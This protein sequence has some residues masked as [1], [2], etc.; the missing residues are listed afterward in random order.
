[1]PV[2]LCDLDD[3]LF[4]HDRATREALAVLQNRHQVLTRWSLDELDA[5]HRVWLETMHLEV[6]AGRL[7]VDEARLERFA[8]VLGDAGLRDEGVAGTL[9]RDY[10]DTYAGRWHPVAGAIELLQ[11]VRAAGHTI[12]IITNNGVAEQ[13]LKLERCGL[14]ACI[15]AMLTSEEAGC[16]KPDRAIFEQALARAG[17][18]AS[19]AVML[20]DAWVADVEGA[21]GA[22]IAPVWLNRTGRPSPDPTVAELSSLLPVNDAMA[23]LRRSGL[24]RRGPGN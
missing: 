22:G 18:R 17:G 20:G 10:R 12:V 4:D 3:T 11:A 13:E 5:R 23:V 8:R 19:D 1:V 7:T 9:A 16:C 21:R 15:D 6:L 2:L 24:G 14:G